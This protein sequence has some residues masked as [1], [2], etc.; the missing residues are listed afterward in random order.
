MSGGG[1][2]IRHM[3]RLRRLAAPGFTL[4]HVESVEHGKVYGWAYMPKDPARRSCVRLMIDSRYVA[5]TIADG[6]RPDLQAKGYGDG[7]H[8]FTLTVPRELLDA[9]EHELQV[10]DA[11]SGQRLS[12]LSQRYRLPRESET[13]P[14]VQELLFDLAFYL[15]QAGAVREP[16]DHYRTAGWKRG[17]QPHPLVATSWYVDR[18]GLVDEDPLTHFER[19]GSRSGFSLHPLIDLKALDASK[20]L[21]SSSVITK[22]LQTATSQGPGP[23]SFFSDSDYAERYPG[24]VEAGFRPLVHYLA[25][26]WQE[27][28]RPHLD[29]DPALFARLAGLDRDVEPYTHFVSTLSRNHGTSDADAKPRVSII[30]V[31]FNKAVL[32]LQ[33]LYFLHR[34]TNADLTEVI[35]VDNGSEADDF[36]L[37][38]RH[39]HQASIVRL[40]ENR[41][42]GEGN[43]IGVEHARG[44]YLVLM[45]NDVFVGADWLEPLLRNVDA[46]PTIGAVGAKLLFADGALQEAGAFVSACGTALQRGKHLDPRLPIFNKT[47]TVDYCS[48]ALILVRA[49][50]FRAVLGFDLC[51]DPAYYEDS[52]LC[53]KLRTLGLRTVYEPRCEVTHLEHATTEVPAMAESLRDVVAINRLKFV[54][55]W[56]QSPPLAFGMDPEVVRRAGASGRTANGS[57]ALYSPYPLTPGGGE[58]YLLTM[59]AT[60]GRDRRCVLFTPDRYS[61]IRLLTMARELGLDLTHVELDEFSHAGSHERFEVFVSMGNEVL[62]PVAGIGRLNVFHCQFPFPLQADQLGDRWRNLASYDGVV[63]NSEFTAEHY[64]LAL[65]GLG[66]KALGIAVVPPPVPQMGLA[67]RPDD[68]SKGLRILSVGRFSPQGHDKRQ[69]LMVQAFAQLTKQAPSSMEL[70]L[71]GT[72]G[73]GHEGRRYLHELMERAR[74]FPVYFHPN[75]GAPQIA[76]LYRSASLYWHLTGAGQDVRLRPELFEHFGISIV[77]AMSAG[78]PPVALGYGGPAEII[79]DGVNGALLADASELA[80]RSEHLLSRPTELLRMGQAAKRRA[81]DF[82]PDRFGRKLAEALASFGACTP[83]I[84]ADAAE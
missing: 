73:S 13:H 67:E 66:M 43:N 76:T 35:V 84:L 51:W 81:L 8:G 1:T 27:G 63:V 62:P 3:K 70:H 65:Q 22:Y 6:Y 46:D 32:T 52:D 48:A 75:A 74:G 78:V 71:A 14:R 58:R 24:V 68:A 77:E 54:D 7:C 40:A 37:L 59:A 41:G 82:S 9:A 50:S 33:C 2:F 39:A 5:E 45:N 44:D 29:F 56:T 28:A 20:A 61:R 49:D 42:F 34:H 17:Y 18:H 53:L 26:G 4:G 30:I 72:I 60:L 64:R 16:L 80:R 11:L 79:Q 31:N 57:L 69:D 25:Y 21:E 36:Q 19:I 55:R 83:V 12:A 15:K 10:L 38:C 23:S 47:E